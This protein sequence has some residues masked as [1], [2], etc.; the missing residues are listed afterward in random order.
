M[1]GKKVILHFHSQGISDL[2]CFRSPQIGHLSRALKISFLKEREEVEKEKKIEKGDIG[3][4]RSEKRE[5]QPAKHKGQ[6]TALR[7]TTLIVKVSRFVA[8]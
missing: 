5:S 6:L 7:A 4:E 3:G 1:L 2:P 8:G